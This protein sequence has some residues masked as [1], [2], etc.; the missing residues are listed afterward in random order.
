MRP[1]PS[2]QNEARQRRRRSRRTAPGSRAAG[3]R[4]AASPRRSC[5][6]RPAARRQPTRD[7]RGNSRSRTTS[8]WRRPGRG[9]AGDR[10]ADRAPRRRA[11]RRAPGRRRSR[12]RRNRRAPAPATSNAPARNASSSTA[13][14]PHSKSI[15]PQPESAPFGGPA[16]GPR[17]DAI[18][19]QAPGRTGRRSVEQPDTARIAS[20][21][22]KA[23]RSPRRRSNAG[24]KQGD[25][26]CRRERRNAK[27]RCALRGQKIPGDGRRA[28]SRRTEVLVRELGRDPEYIRDI[29]EVDTEPA[30]SGAARPRPTAH[31][32]P[33]RGASA[34]R[35]GRRTPEEMGKSYSA[36]WPRLLSGRI[37][38][39]LGRRAGGAAAALGLLDRA[40]CARA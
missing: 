28:N 26:R 2:V 20:R 3:R 10:P 39:V 35:T 36:G 18:R 31:R 4:R 23:S 8:R 17:L 34:T 19:F 33:R 21:A 27:G 24:A 9:C 37:S 14:S 1:R 6:P 7:R 25:R 38:G 5:R 32:S 40:R 13:A 11:A 22:A 30:K 15:T 29:D 16:P 12:R